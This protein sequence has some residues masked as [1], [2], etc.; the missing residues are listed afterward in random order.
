MSDSNSGGLLTGASGLRVLG[1]PGLNALLNAF[2]TFVNVRD[3]GLSVE[4]F[5]H[6]AAAAAA[7]GGGTQQ[8]QGQEP[9]GGGGGGGGSGGELPPVVA[10]ELVNITPVVIQAAMD[11]ARGREGSAA[12][13]EGGEP[14]A[15]RQRTVGSCSGGGQAAMTSVAVESPAACYICELP[16]IPGKF[17]PQKVRIQLRG[18]QGAGRARHDG[19]RRVGCMG[20]KLEASATGCTCPPPLGPCAPPTPGCTAHQAASLGVPRGPLYGQL[21]KG[22]EVVA[23]NGRVVKP[24]DV[25][26]PSVPGPLVLVVDCPSPAFLPALRAAPALAEL[27]GGPRGTRLAAAVHLAPRDVTALPEYRAWLAGFPAATTHILVA[28]SIAQDV[29]IQ[30]R[31]A[32]LQVGDPA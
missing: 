30:R 28:E 14:Q 8:G 5:G 9:E 22:E 29:P 15:K 18:L 19:G 23:A 21:V 10:N 1:P 13:G 17:L 27:A 24:S 6:V 16:E 12:A 32:A 26:E 25:M 31:A 4:E 20:D 3:M 2:R 7:P 11:P